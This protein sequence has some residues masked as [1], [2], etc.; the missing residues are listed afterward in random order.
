MLVN[1]SWDVFFFFCSGPG[2]S[3][4]PFASLPSRSVAFDGEKGFLSGVG[5][6]SVYV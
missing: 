6:V 2:L 3:V 4:D 5:Y 1:D